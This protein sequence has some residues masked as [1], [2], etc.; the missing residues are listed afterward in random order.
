MNILPPKYERTVREGRSSGLK[1]SDHSNAA[2]FAALFVAH[3]SVQCQRKCWPGSEKATAG[4][5][6]RAS[7]A[8]PIS[9]S[10]CSLRLEHRTNRKALQLLIIVPCMVYIPRLHYSAGARA[11]TWRLNWTKKA[12]PCRSSSFQKEIS[13]FL[14][15]SEGPP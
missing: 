8:A 12:V 1:P 11:R 15:R 14:F 6:V 10:R 9:F 4:L 2:P 7:T 13:I 3:C 5:F